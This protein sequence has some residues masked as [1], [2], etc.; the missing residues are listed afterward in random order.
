MPFANTWQGYAILDGTNAVAFAVY[1]A[2]EVSTVSEALEWVR[3]RFGLDE[4]DPDDP[5][6]DALSRLFLPATFANGTSP[7]CLA[8]D[9]LAFDWPLYNGFP[10]NKPFN[11]ATDSRAFA[12][13]LIDLLERLEAVTVVSLLLVVL[14][15]VFA[16]KSAIKLG[17][18]FFESYNFCLQMTR[19]NVNG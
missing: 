14:C 3:R 16:G 7:F 18:P 4:R 1:S 12:V 19:Q 5:A 15:G 13:S 11:E 10:G 17:K 8:F 9:C 6:W 2:S